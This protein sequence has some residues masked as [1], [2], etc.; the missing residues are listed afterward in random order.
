MDALIF[1]LYRDR[2]VLTSAEQVDSGATLL[3]PPVRIVAHAD[4]AHLKSVLD[5]LLREVPP[6]VPQPDYNSVRFVKDLRLEPLG[7]RSWK[8]FVR[9]AR[10]FNLER[11]EEKL[12]LEEWP[13]E[14]GNF[15]ARADWQQEFPGIGTKLLVDW[16]VELTEPDLPKPKGKAK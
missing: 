10:C 9:G 14:G 16:I 1:C 4:R 11:K 3:A 2:W 12:L 13:R 8:A 5:E 6:V 7:L 15:S